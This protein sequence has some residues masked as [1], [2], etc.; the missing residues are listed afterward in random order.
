MAERDKVLRLLF[1]VVDEM[2][3]ALPEEEQIATAEDTAIFG[4]DAG[5]DSLSL[6]NLILDVETKLA[7]TVGAGPNLSE[8]LIG[9]DGDD[10]P[11]TL[12]TLASFIAEFEV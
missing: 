4:V 8:V 7:E 6:L 3:E 1:E 12:G 2:N 11:D 5:L 9:N 10:V